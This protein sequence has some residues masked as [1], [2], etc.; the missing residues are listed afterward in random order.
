M[1]QAAGQLGDFGVLSAKP[2]VGLV[3][4]DGLGSAGFSSAEGADPAPRW[5]R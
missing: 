2:Q 3:L 1:R 5:R 4:I